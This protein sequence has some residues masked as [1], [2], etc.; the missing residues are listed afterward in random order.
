M[1]HLRQHPLRLLVSIAFFFMLAYLFQDP[2]IHAFY[3]TVYYSY[4][5]DRDSP[6]QEIAKKIERE[7]KLYHP[8]NNPLN[9]DSKYSFYPKD[10]AKYQFWINSTKQWSKESPGPALIIDK[11]AG[12]LFLIVNGDVLHSLPVSLSPNPYTDKYMQGDGAT[13][14]GLYEVLRRTV[15]PDEISFTINYPS[16]TDRSEFDVH[17]YKGLLPE[18]ANIDEQIALSINT[19]SNNDAVI[20]VAPEDI[21]YLANSG[22]SAG[23]PITII[24]YGMLSDYSRTAQQLSK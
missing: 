9:L 6:P 11:A 10:Y 15:L 22:V 2:R 8:I 23:T 14:E 17:M 18:S 19:D 16:N 20:L 4:F 24:R 7:H 12:K 1:K 5:V 21:A 3:N 13:P